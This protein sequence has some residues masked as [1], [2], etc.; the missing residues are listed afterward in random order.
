MSR[1][2]YCPNFV[3]F[4]ISLFLL[5]FSTAGNSQTKTAPPRQKPTNSSAATATASGEIRYKGI[6]EPVSYPEDLE[7]FDVFFSSPDEGWVSGEKRDNPA[8]H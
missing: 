2:K 8:Y 1:R 7:L 6:F 3:L 5:V 4:M